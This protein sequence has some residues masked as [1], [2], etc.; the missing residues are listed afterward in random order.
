LPEQLLDK[1]DSPWHRSLTFDFD[2]GSQAYGVAVIGY[3]VAWGIL[4]AFSHLLEKNYESPSARALN[5]RS[6]AVSSRIFETAGSF[7]ILTGSR[8]CRW[9]EGD[10]LSSLFGA[11]NDELCIS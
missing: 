11:S 8:P 2:F 7:S 9:Q 5:S 10:G 4:F 1:K 3:L 6:L